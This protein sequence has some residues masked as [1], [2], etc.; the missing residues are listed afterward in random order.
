MPKRPIP[1]ADRMRLYRTRRR[2]GLRS[3][4]ILLAEEEI[5][6]LVAKGFMRSERRHLSTAVQDALERFICSELGPPE[7]ERNRGLRERPAGM[8]GPAH[9]KRGA[10]P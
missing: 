2:N 4:R 6:V 10:G 5:D 8:Q 9:L 1:A 3:V 7:H